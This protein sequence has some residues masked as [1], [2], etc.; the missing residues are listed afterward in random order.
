VGLT[1]FI[2]PTGDEAA[3]LQHIAAYYRSFT[4]AKH[5]QA[6]PFVFKPSR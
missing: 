2:T 4:G 1:E 3:D 6:S 5:A